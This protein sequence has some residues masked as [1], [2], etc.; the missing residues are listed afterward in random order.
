[1]QNHFTWHKDHYISRYFICFSFNKEK[2]NSPDVDRRP[3]FSIVSPGTVLNSTKAMR[4]D[5]LFFSYSAEVSEL[6][7]TVF[8]P[9]T[10]ERRV[11]HFLQDEKF[12]RY[13]SDIRSLLQ[14]RTVIG[15]VDKLDVLAME[16]TLSMIADVGKAEKTE[17]DP[18]SSEGKLNEIAAK[19]RGGA[20]LE[21]LIRQYGFSRRRFYYEWNRLFPVSPKQM[22]LEAK[23]EKAQLLLQNTVLPIMEIAME[24]GFSSHRYFHE[25]FQKYYL[26]TPGEYRK[27]F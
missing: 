27:R 1:M 23:L 12:C 20:S 14:K 25:C 17:W 21:P 11:F 26:C 15:V 16:M 6:L 7:K 13:L 5:E 18:L 8:N 22:Q 24:C 19:L 4:H 9:V 3:S 2:Y 10:S